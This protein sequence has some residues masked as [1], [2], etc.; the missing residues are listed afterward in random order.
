MTTSELS[1]KQGASASASDQREREP[2]R[3]RGSANPDATPARCRLRWYQEQAVAAVFD[4][5]RRESGAPCVVLPTGSGKTHVIAELCRQVVAW[6]GRALVLAHVK[7]LLEQS[8]EKLSRV[9]PAGMVGVYSAGLNE[10]TTDAPVIVAGIQSV[11]QRAEELGE[12]FL[13]VVDEAHLIPPDGVGRYRTLLEAEKTVSPKARLV[14]LTATPYRLGC[15]WIV[16][17]KAP[18]SDYDRL[19]DTIVYEVP[20]SDLIADGT[21]S[22]VVSKQARRSPDFSSVH[23]KRGE[24]DAE[25]VEKILGRKNVLEAA[26]LEIVEQTRD[27]QKVLVFCNRRESA[28]RCA[29]LLQEYDAEHAAEIVDGET[30]ADK[31]AE[32]TRRF[33]TSEPTVDLLGR[34]EKTLKYVCN[35]GVL[36]T[37]FDAPNVD[38][39]AILRPTQS[40]TL[41]QQIVG[42][43]LRRSPDKENCLV[44]DY[45]G[46]VDRFGPIDLPN[47][48]Q[49]GESTAVKRWKTCPEC[50]AVVASYCAVCPL[51]GKEFPKSAPGDPNKN[52]SSRASSK[53]FLS[54]GED[55]PEP[56]VEEYD[57]REVEYSAHYKKDD[58]DK[59][60]TL[61]VAYKRGEFARPVFEWLCPGHPLKWA[62]GRFERW[63]KAKSKTDPPTD[64]ETAAFYAS[65]GALAVPTKIR[66]TT[67]PGERFPSIEWLE[68]GEIPN[69]D[70]NKIKTD[71]EEFYEGFEEFAAFDGTQSE[72]DSADALDADPR[73]DDEKNYEIRE[74]YAVPQ[75]C[76]SAEKKTVRCQNC[77][78]WNDY[79]LEDYSGFCWAFNCEQFGTSPACS[80]HFKERWI[81]PELPF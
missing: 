44:L 58:P 24:Y 22:T 79:G 37:G 15:G 9:L 26:C 71:E 46:N 2:N 18:E 7:E 73:A 33:K 4:Y 31:R 69:F 77:G 3:P 66:I 49:T 47:P 14:G 76:S 54:D 43:G 1:E 34:V 52:L 20:I 42:R 16:K 35:V 30:P 19:L 29:K 36:T 55:A 65:K 81:D 80:E 27:R 53:S 63:W 5:L 60:P 74:L 45:G 11:Y 70:P 64:A 38:A 28:R 48:P 17:D 12:F 57:V 13:I 68:F 62:R 75:S 59:P 61:Q 6:R 8:R 40:L 41:Y 51:C 78:E 50:R 56:T 10:R 72:K 23:V 39:V 25:E 21:L 32:I 67:N